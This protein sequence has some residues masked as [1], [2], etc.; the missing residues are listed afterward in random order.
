MR[1]RKREKDRECVSCVRVWEREEEAERE[2]ERE[3]A[4]VCRCVGSPH[5][6]PSARTNPSMLSST[7]CPLIE[8]YDHRAPGDETIMDEVTSEEG[9]AEAPRGVSASIDDDLEVEDDGE[10]RG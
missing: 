6:S 3:R 10:E 2:R 4:C 7:L 8:S 9:E 5:R 1:G